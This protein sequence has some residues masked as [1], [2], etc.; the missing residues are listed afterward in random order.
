MPSMC[1][2]DYYDPIE[3]RPSIME[4][5][6]TYYLWAAEGVSK[7]NDKHTII[8]DWDQLKQIVAKEEYPQVSID[9]RELTIEE[10]RSLVKQMWAIGVHDVFLWKGGLRAKVDK[11]DI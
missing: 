3:G 8:N 11:E 6:Y 9:T 5:Y 2:S 4:S 7:P 10:G 1:D